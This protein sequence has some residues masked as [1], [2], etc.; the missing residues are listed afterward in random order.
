[1]KSPS[2]L[3]I[4]LVPAAILLIPLVAMK[5][6]DEVDWSGSDFVIMYVLMTSIG[7]AYKI[8]TRKA[9]SAWYRAAAALGLGAAF[10]LIW[11]NL[12]VGFIGD[13]DNPA[14][15]LY[16]GVLL[17][18]A[19][20]AVIARCE[21]AGMSRAMFATAAAQ[22]VVPIVAFLAWRPNFDANV[23][24]IFLLN[25]FWVLMFGVSGAWFRHAARTT[26]KT[27]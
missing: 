11:V 1:M 27:A 22:F 7:L 10:L 2:L 21:P 4:L 26:L 5:F 15:A 17:V 6:S 13:E 18:G 9:E 12:A 3:T 24:L 20:G 14:N 23:M 8:L 16:L 19:A 25:S